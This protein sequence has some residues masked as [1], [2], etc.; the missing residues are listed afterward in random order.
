MG[1]DL[2]FGLAAA[3]ALVIMTMGGFALFAR[4]YRKV[5]QGRALVISKM[6]GDPEVTFS[7]GLVLPV[8]HRAEEM[9]I[10]V[11]TIEID[12]RGDEGLICQDN[13]RGDI[14]VAFFVRV[15][16]TADDVLELAGGVN[17]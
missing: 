11:K 15:N 16:K 12:R 14:K 17:A 10:S 6:A 7:G 5:D 3:G 1:A 2:I 8:I 9:D 4:F 13:I